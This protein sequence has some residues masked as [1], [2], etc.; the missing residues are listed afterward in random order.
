[1]RSVLLAIL[2]A[3]VA[4]GQA[5]AETMVERGRYLVEVLAACGHCHTPRGPQGPIPEQHLAGGVVFTE[6]FGVAVSRNL[7]PDPETGL[8]T[9]TDEEIIRA[10]REGKSKDG[11]T[12]GPPMPFALYRRI[13]DRHVQAMVAYLQTLPPIKHEILPSQYTVTLPAAYGPPV[14]SARAVDG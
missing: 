5:Q 14:L 9:W 7:T 11:H 10:I 2:T 13:S 3:G 12:L 1:M 6:A 4:A 8:G